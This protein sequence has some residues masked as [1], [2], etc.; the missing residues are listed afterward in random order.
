MS[1]C[2]SRKLRFRGTVRT[3]PDF[4]EPRMKPCRSADSTSQFFRSLLASELE[5]SAKTGPR[6]IPSKLRIRGG[7]AIGLPGSSSSSLLEPLS[8][9]M[10]NRVDGLVVFRRN[11]LR[12]P[13]FSNRLRIASGKSAP[14]FPRI[15][16]SAPSLAAAAEA[17]MALPPGEITVR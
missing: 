13:I 7:A 14:T 5:T 4:E 12:I 15:S 3:S 1:H 11:L 16:T 6:W 8:R 10:R 9:V 17:N 2:L